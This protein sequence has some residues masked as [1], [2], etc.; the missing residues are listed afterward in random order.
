MKHGPESPIRSLKILTAPPVLFRAF[1]KAT[2]VVL[3]WR[4]TL[5]ERTC[6]ACDCPLDSTAISVNINGKPVEVCCN[7]CA[8][9]L[10]E[11]GATALPEG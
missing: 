5:N 6:A 4:K 7:E 10:N 2:N 3:K 8:L 11:A 9:A 1:F